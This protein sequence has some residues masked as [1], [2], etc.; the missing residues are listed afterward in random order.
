MAKADDIKVDPGE[1]RAVPLPPESP[2]QPR[3][4]TY[5]DL[6][7]RPLVLC[8]LHGLDPAPRAG[9]NGA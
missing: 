9:R 7:E 6:W 8:A 1:A 4:V 2:R 3:A 5:L